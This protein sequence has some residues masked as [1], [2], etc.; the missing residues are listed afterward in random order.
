MAGLW[1]NQAETREGKYLVKRRDGS[2]PE[3]PHFVIG[4]ADPAA[5]DALR[6]YAD[7]A[8]RLGMDP[9]YVADVRD[10][11]TRF[12]RY[13]RA[14]GAGDPDAPRHRKDDPATVAEMARAA[15]LGGGSA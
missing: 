2:V 5:P 4:G 13:R 10:L 14:I 15:G 11:A 8:E 1:R 3:W 6:A 9:V 7:A 12:E